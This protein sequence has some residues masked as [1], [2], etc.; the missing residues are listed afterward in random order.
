LAPGAF[1]KIAKTFFIPPHSL[2]CGSGREVSRAHPTCR[3]GP[4]PV[5]ERGYSATEPLKA[6][7]FTTS[8]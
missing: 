1:R 4:F 3:L 8:G 6:A 5:S 7:L 2:S